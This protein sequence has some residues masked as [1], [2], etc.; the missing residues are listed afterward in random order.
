MEFKL[1]NNPI[2]RLQRPASTDGVV[3]IERIDVKLDKCICFSHMEVEWG[4]WGIA[5]QATVFLADEKGCTY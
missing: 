1:T 5:V 2:F 4:K 3:Y